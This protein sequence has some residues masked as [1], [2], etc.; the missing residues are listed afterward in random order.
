MSNPNPNQENLKNFKDM[1]PE[2]RSEI[3]KKGAEV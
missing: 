1:T 2:E 3:A